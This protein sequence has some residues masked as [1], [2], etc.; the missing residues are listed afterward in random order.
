MGIALHAV[1]ALANGTPD[2]T[3]WQRCPDTRVVVR[4]A[5][6]RDADDACHGARRA[7]DFFRT[8]ELRTDAPIVVEILKELPDIVSPTAA[9]AFLKSERRVLLQTYEKFSANATWFEVPVDRRL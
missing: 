1:Q 9:G 6:G 7:L 3:G 2:D 5:V 4:A 8:L